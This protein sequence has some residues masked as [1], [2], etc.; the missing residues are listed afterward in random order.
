M[1]MSNSTIAMALDNFHIERECHELDDPKLALSVWRNKIDE[2]ISKYGEDSL[3]GFD[4]GHNN[5][6]ATIYHEVCHD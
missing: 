6:E 3:L 4:A 5:V 1:V 2:L